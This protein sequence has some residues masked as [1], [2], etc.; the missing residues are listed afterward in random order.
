ME[1]APND[2]GGSWFG[3]EITRCKGKGRGYETF[4]EFLRMHE[5]HRRET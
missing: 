1:K 5:H 4:F 3:R 2:H